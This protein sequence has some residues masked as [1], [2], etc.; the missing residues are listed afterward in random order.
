AFYRRHPEVRARQGD[1][2]DRS[3]GARSAP[4]AS[5][6]FPFTHEGGW[7]A[8]RRNI[9]VVWR[10][11]RDAAPSGAP[12][13]RFQPRAALLL[14]RVD[15]RPFAL[16]QP[17]PGGRPVRPPGGAPRL[18]VLRVRNAAAGAASRSAQTTPRE[19]APCRAGMVVLIFLD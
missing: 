1:V 2:R 14:G 13:R 12:S 10:L 8:G 6:G 7:S 17:A 19:S 9:L 3:R 15:F 5:S 18:P 11:L 4:E 16:F